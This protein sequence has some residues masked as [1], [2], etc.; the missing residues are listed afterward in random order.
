[1]SNK[2]EFDE[3]QEQVNYVF[4]AYIGGNQKD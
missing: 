4:R 1:M 3:R 2:I